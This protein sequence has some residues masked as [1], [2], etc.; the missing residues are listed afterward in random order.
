MVKL[1]ATSTTLQVYTRANTDTGMTMTRYLFRIILMVDFMF[2]ADSRA[3]SDLIPLSHLSPIA[4]RRFLCISPL[5]CY[6]FPFMYSSILM[7]EFLPVSALGILIPNLSLPYAL[8]HSPRMTR[9]TLRLFFFHKPRSFPGL[10]ISARLLLYMFLPAY[11]VPFHVYAFYFAQSC[12]MLSL[13]CF[14]FLVSIHSG[15]SCEACGKGVVIMVQI[16]RQKHVPRIPSH[17]EP[18][19][20]YHR[21]NRD[22]ST[23]PR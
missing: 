14:A 6:L 9:S 12:G 18:H 4:L 5:L 23:P 1:E 2:P 22:H 10:F 11:Y 13:V 8:P 16:T 15:T 17:S 20:G 7:L 21:A 19:R 3:N